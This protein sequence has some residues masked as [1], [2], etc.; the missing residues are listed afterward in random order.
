MPSGASVALLL[1]TPLQPTGMEQMRYL[2]IMKYL[3]TLLCVLSLAATAQAVEQRPDRLVEQTTEEVLGIIKEAQGYYEQDPERFYQEVQSVLGRVVDFDSFARGVMGKYAGKDY[4][5]SLSAEG[6]EQLKQQVDR[7]SGVFRDGL[8]QT[9]AKGLLAFNGNKT[10]VLPVAEDDV[11][12]GKVTVVQQ[13]YGDRD[14]PYEVMYLLRK[15]KQGQ[16]KF[17]NVT[18]DAVNLGQVYRSQFYSAVKQY[19]GDIDKV[20]DNWALDE[21]ANEQ[22]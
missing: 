9:Y 16:W 7:F 22:Q 4:Y 6:R 11:V 10:E 20:I 18:I 14:T 19:D 15:D 1:K 3:L 13:I 12:T 21:P 5:L 2:S 17:R 8:V